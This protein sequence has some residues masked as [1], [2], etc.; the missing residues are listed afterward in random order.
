MKHFE[1]FLAT[2]N[3]VVAVH[4]AFLS[5]AVGHITDSLIQIIITA[6]FVTAISAPFYRR[7]LETVT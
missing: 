7:V 2:Q 3:F 4:W 5:L 1:N 6:F